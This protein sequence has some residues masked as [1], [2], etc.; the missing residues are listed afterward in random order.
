[1]VNWPNQHLLSPQGGCVFASADYKRLLTQKG[2]SHV[3]VL[4]HTGCTLIV[5]HQSTWARFEF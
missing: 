2:G 5:P 1:M 3:Q 4:R